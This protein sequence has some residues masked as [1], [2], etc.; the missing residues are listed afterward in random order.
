MDG[1]DAALVEIRGSADRTAR[2]AAS[3]SLRM[4]YPTGSAAR[5]CDVSP[6]GNPTAAGN[7]SQLNF[8]LGEL[9][10][11]AALTVCRRARVSPNDLSGHR[12]ARPDDLPPGDAVTRSRKANRQHAANC[13]A[14]RDR[15]ADRRSGGGGFSHRRHGG[16][17][18]GRAARADGGLPTA[19]RRARRTRGAQHRRHRQRHGDSR[20][21]PSPKRSSASTPVRATW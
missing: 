7:I 10:A 11:E 2:A 8:L 16:G 13:R 3:R 17:R 21:A 9:F 12:L 20:A 6:Q 5:I 18:P 15:R 1:V 4:P 19:A 14:G